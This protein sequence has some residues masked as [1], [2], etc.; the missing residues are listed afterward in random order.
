MADL[1]SWLQRIEQLHPENIELSLERVASVYTQLECAGNSATVV[2]VAGTNGK[3]TTVECLAKCLQAQGLNVGAYTSPHLI[4]FNERIC[5]NGKQVDDEQIV[6]AFERVDA[7]RGDTEL[8]YFEFTTLAALEVFTSTALDVWLLEVGMGGRLDAVNVVESE[9]AIVTSIGLDHQSWLGDTRE[10]VGFEKAG[11]M[12]ADKQVFCSD[13]QPPLSVAN[14]AHAIGARFSQLGR[15]FSYTK[16]A[17]LWNWQG[18]QA[19]RKELQLPR[20][21]ILDNLAGALAA[22]EYLDALPSVGQLNEIFNNWS[23]AG[24]QQRI[25]GDVGWWLDVA[26]NAESARQLGLAISHDPPQG[27]CLCI[28]GMLDDKPV[29][30]LIGALKSHISHWFL[31]RLDSHRALDP[32]KLAE[33]LEKINISEY[34]VLNSVAAGCALA[35]AQACA[36]DRIVVT[37]SFHSVGPALAW[38][39]L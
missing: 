39:G 13:P 3:G 22:L 36:G 5:I 7:T 8:T 31:V 4:R 24:R 29:D 9:V 20:G 38:L 25:E 2:T 10:L 14:H 6:A 19:Q 17:G 27:Q 32:A 18:L 28:V 35:R 34:Q 15:H 30:A 16:S 37:G 23:F 11:I 12:R 21:A 33:T 1:K 26:H